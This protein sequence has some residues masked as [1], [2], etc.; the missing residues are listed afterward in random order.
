MCVHVCLCVYVAEET[1]VLRYCGTDIMG[2]PFLGLHHGAMLLNDNP[3]SDVERGRN[4]R[5]AKILPPRDGTAPRRNLPRGLLNLPV[6]TR[7][8]EFLGEQ[9]AK[10]LEKLELSLQNVAVT[11]RGKGP[12]RSPN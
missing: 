4:P 8:L 10:K 2:N 7:E 11:I 9:E 1:A 3:G 5:E 12:K 6:M